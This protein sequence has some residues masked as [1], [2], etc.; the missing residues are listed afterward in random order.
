[1]VHKKTRLF[2]DQKRKY[3]E[4]FDLESIVK[5]EEFPLEQSAKILTDYGL[6]LTSREVEDLMQFLNTLAKITLKEVFQLNSF[7][8]FIFFKCSNNQ[9]FNSW[10]Y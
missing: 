3:S 10:Q 6:N 5:F 1:M 7:L 9:M 4:N 2:K 8:Y